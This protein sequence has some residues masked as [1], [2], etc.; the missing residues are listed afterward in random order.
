MRTLSWA[1]K[2]ESHFEILVAFLG[3]NI[4][5][6]F[7]IPIIIFAVT[8]LVWQRKTLF[9]K[10]LPRDQFLQTSSVVEQEALLPEVAVLK[11]GEEKPFKPS[12]AQNAHVEFEMHNCSQH[13]P[14][15][16]AGNYMNFHSCNFASPNAKQIY[17]DEK[18][19]RP[20]DKQKSK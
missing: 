1:K 6:L 4:I 16:C 3:L 9:P 2:R 11:E 19:P 10:K 7:M 15:R 8:L 18:K 20:S 5:F 17:W 13:G 14:E 12:G